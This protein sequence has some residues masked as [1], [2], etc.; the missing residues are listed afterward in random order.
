MRK[1]TLYVMC[2]L[3]GSGKSTWAKHY[4]INHKDENVFIVSSDEIRKE[5][6]GVY[7]NLNYEK[8]V[9]EIYFKRLDILRDSNK[10]CTIIADSTNIINAHRQILGRLP[11]F[12]K[13]TLVVITKDLPVILERNRKRDSAKYVPENA[14]KEMWKNWEKV[15]EETAKLFDEVVYVDGWFDK[16]SI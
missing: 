13:K 16:D 11:G 6:T 4:K 3:P 14:I 12:D 15:D 8:E 10:D 1:H 9:W 2:G 7:Q 5:L